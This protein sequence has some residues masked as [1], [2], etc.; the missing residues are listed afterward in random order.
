MRVYDIA[1]QCMLYAQEPEEQGKREYYPFVFE[2]GFS[3]WK[4]G[5]LSGPMLWTGLRDKAGKEVWDGDV[6][7]KG[8]FSWQ[9]EWRPEWGKYILKNITPMP[10]KERPI[11]MSIQQATRMEVV[12]NVWESSSQEV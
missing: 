1:N 10:E 7:Q 2:I 11:Y 9:V 12:G 4:K 5:D 8:R 6:V 3:H